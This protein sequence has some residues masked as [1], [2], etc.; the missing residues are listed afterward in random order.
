MS[1]VTRI[2]EIYHVFFQL[3]FLTTYSNS[4]TCSES[5]FLI[6]FSNLADL[7]GFSFDFSLSLRLPFFTRLSVSP[8][9]SVASVISQ[10]KINTISILII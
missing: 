8:G 5:C 1:E 4:V 9:I 3:N 7:S 6:F 10:N 2:C